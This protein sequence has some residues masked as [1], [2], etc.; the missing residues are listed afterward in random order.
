VFDGASGYAQ[1][2]DAIRC[3]DLFPYTDYF[4]I[5]SHAYGTGKLFW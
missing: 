5:G 2:I 4:I 1:S 3:G